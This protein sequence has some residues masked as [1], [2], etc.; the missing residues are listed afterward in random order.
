ME[1]VGDGGL[2]FFEKFADEIEIV[3]GGAIA[4]NDAGEDVDVDGS[5]GRMHDKFLRRFLDRLP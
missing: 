3:E 1:K 4:C 2:L 5:G